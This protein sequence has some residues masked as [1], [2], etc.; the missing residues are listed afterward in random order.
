MVAGDLVNTASPAPIRR[1]A[2]HGP[3]RRGDAASGVGPA[4]VFEPAGDQVLKG[5]A[6]RSRRG[7]PCGSSPSAAAAA[8]ASGSRRR[9]SVVTTSSGCSRTL[10]HR[11]GSRAARPARL[12]HR[13]GGHRQEPPRVGAP[14]VHRRRGRAPSTGTTAGRRPTAR[15]SRSG[16][17]ARWSAA[18]RPGSRPTTRRTTRERIAAT[19][20]EFVPDETERR[21]IEPALLSLLGVDGPPAAAPRSCSPPGGRSS[22]ASRSGAPSCS[23]SRISTGPIAGLL[24]F[25]D[26]LA[27]VDRRAA[28]PRRHPRP[29]RAARPAAGLGSRRAGLHR[30]SPSSHSPMTRWGSCSTALVPGLP[31]PPSATI[32][33]RAD[34]IPLYAVETVRMLAADGRLEEADGVVTAPSGRP[35]R[36]RPSPSYAPV[37]HR[38]ATR[39]ARAGDRSLV[40]QDAAVLG[41]T[42]TVAGLGSSAVSSGRRLGG[43]ACG[44]SSDASSSC[45]TRIQRSPERGQYGFVQALVREVAY[46]TLAKRDGGA[47]TSPRRASSRP[48]ARRSSPASSPP[49]TSPRG[50]RRRTTGRE[51]L[52]AQARHR[53]AS[54]GRAG[55]QPSGRTSRR[56]AFLERAREVT[57]GDAEDTEL[58]ERIADVERS[59][60]GSRPRSVTS[61]RS[62][63]GTGRPATSPGSSARR[64]ALGEPTRAHRAPLMPWR[65]ASR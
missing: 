20:S 22:S 7:G 63:N 58:L 64:R 34:G 57:A 4:I 43:A 30:A 3:R 47:G 39:R 56:C 21:W 19:S 46:A 53:P 35:R 65:C 44:R 2:R 50:R 60:V 1:A 31:E 36:P 25:I 13:T 23:C 29:A 32:I 24:D 11:H 9:S 6:A 54:R 5:K 40:L 42:F 61:R 52:A 14:Q 10:L 48:S 51:A 38:G 28:D 37:A 45:S 33:A 15:A 16:R 17:S 55:E 49:T 62:S 8:A 18:G 27:R 41:Q 59:S 26:H 12:G